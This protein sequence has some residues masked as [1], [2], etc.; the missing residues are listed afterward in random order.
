VLA[1]GPIDGYF[2]SGSGVASQEQFHSARGFVKAFLEAQIDVPVAIRLGGNAEDKAVAILEWLNGWVP[3]PVEGFKK[4]N[5]PDFAP[6][7]AHADPGGQ[8]GGAQDATA[9]RGAGEAAP[10]PI[11]DGHGG[12]ITYD[13]SICAGCRARCA[14]ESACPKILS[15]NE[16]GLPVLNIA[17]GAKGR[18]SGCLACEVDVSSG[19]GRWADRA[20]DPGD[21]LARTSGGGRKGGEPASCGLLWGLVGLLLELKQRRAHRYVGHANPASESGPG[22]QLDIRTMAAAGL[23]FFPSSAKMGYA[24]VPGTPFGIDQTPACAR[25]GHG[26]HSE[27]ADGS[28]TRT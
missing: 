5:P 14:C 15:L 22:H 21:Y 2:G 20:A 25:A 16:G 7:A 11:P 12:T 4:D 6:P 24:R 17:R 23:A 1:T 3:V 27:D 10:L 9:P 26:D 19:R 28:R 18:C 13:H 8:A